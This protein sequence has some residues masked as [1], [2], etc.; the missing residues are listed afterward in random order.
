MRRRNA[1]IGL[2]L[3]AA[4]ALIST[5]VAGGGTGTKKRGPRG[6]AG[7]AGPQ[8]PEGIQ[9]PTGANGTAR[10]FVHVTDADATQAAVDA[11]NSSPAGIT[12]CV[13]GS[14]DVMVNLPA[15][16]VP[17]KVVVTPDTTGSTDPTL[18]RTVRVS[19]G[20]G[21]G[22]GGLASSFRV[23]STLTTTGAAKDTGFFA[24]IN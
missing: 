11:A 16:L 6:F 4:L 13:N 8:G 19:L 15:G 1:M 17:K 12:L 20:G 22:C 5:A 24:L 3:I 9:G 18:A 2:A 14:G 10:A 21:G 7:V 23:I